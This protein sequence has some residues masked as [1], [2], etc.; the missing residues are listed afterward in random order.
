MCLPPQQTLFL[1]VGDCIWFFCCLVLSNYST[2]CNI[3]FSCKLPLLQ[4]QAVFFCFL[5]ILFF[6]FSP[7]SPP[8]H[9]CMF[10]VVC[11]FSCGMWDAASAWFDEECHVRAQ[12]SN[13]RNTGLP[14]A[15]RANL[16]TR[17]QGQPPQAVLNIV[18]TCFSLQN[19]R[20]YCFF[21]TCKNKKAYL[22]IKLFINL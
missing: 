12:D 10:F 2:N 14:A 3:F 7:Q 21:A 11:P 5:K 19:G 22:K 6:P 15:E 13:Q 17:P 8:V 18:F 4:T 16:T 20:L 9:S 1:E